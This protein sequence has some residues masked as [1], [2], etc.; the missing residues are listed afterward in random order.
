MSRS[1]SLAYEYLTR[2]G[3]LARLSIRNCKAPC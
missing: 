3:P 2:L 1:V